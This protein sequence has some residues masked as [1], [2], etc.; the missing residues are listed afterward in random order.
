[1]KIT[2]QINQDLSNAIKMK[3]TIKTSALRL[4]KGSYQTIKGG[5]KEINI[6]FE[7]VILILK[8]LIHSE[9]KR[10]L[11]ELKLISN[12][13]IIREGK[14]IDEFTE[15]KLKE[16]WNELKST[17]IEIWE[18]YIP[19][20]PTEDE[21]K[22]W[23]KD[24]VNLEKYKDNIMKAMK[25]IKLNFPLNDGTQIKNILLSLKGN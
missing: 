9:K 25:D 22:Q 8:K 23:I 11:F 7:N 3:N 18:S 14:N 16:K 4:I 6:T 10:L 15:K 2:E 20:L 5:E 21:I 13:D 19:K 12:E 17:Y 1:M 24:N